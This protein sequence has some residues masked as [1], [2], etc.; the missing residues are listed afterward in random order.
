MQCCAPPP[1]R[2]GNH[3]GLHC[4]GSSD[5]AAA[6]VGVTP[7][8]RVRVP[9]AGAALRTAARASRGSFRSAFGSSSDYAA[10]TVG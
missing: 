1:A 4:C 3:T 10:A 6:T 8:V 2:H 7:Q 9:Q 5:Y